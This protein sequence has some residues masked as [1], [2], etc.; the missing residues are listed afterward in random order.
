MCHSAWR[1]IAMARLA[2]NGA[3]RAASFFRVS[4]SDFASCPRPS[5]FASC[6]RFA[7]PWTL[8]PGAKSSIFRHLRSIMVDQNCLVH[9][10]TQPR[11]PGDRANP[12]PWSPPLFPPPP[13]PGLLQPAP[14]IVAYSVLDPT[15]RRLTTVCL[16]SRL[17]ASTRCSWPRAKFGS[18]STPGP[19]LE[20]LVADPSQSL[21]NLR[22][23][24]CLIRRRQVCS[25]LCLTLYAY[26]TYHVSEHAVSSKLAAMQHV[27]AR[28]PNAMDSSHGSLSALHQPPL[29]ETAPLHYEMRVLCREYRVGII[30]MPCAL[31]STLILDAAAL[32]SRPQKNG[33]T[34]AL[35]QA[36]SSLVTNS[37]HGIEWAVSANYTWLLNPADASNTEA[38]RGVA[39][40]QALHDLI[41]DWGRSPKST[42]RVATALTLT[43]G[44]VPWEKRLTATGWSM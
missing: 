15:R 19:Q 30:V 25:I 21:C 44:S 29:Q 28:H 40:G 39:Q 32:S 11:N 26:I 9:H 36:R 22:E 14:A 5:D 34:A 16:P 41:D 24:T 38:T 33:P 31:Q 3:S 17:L 27:H 7:M 8:L 42:S 23:A 4:P 37:R 6:P 35:D 13:W 12:P 18:L 20:L 2:V 10:Q 1:L 43:T